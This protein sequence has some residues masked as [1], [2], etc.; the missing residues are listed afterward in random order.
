MSKAI[1]FFD[2]EKQFR[3]NSERKQNELADQ[4]ETKINSLGVS[5]D[6]FKKLLKNWKKSNF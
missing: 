2:W 4:K 3:P 6:A 5:E 1:S